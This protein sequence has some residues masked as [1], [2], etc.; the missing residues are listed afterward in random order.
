MENFLSTQ[1]KWTSEKLLRGS[2]L[3]LS[4]GQTQTSSLGACGQ[5][6]AGSQSL[7]QEEQL[8][9]VLSWVQT[10]WSSGHN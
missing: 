4:D 7:E 9:D 6:L 10:F 2:N 8:G 1:S 3:Q 5:I